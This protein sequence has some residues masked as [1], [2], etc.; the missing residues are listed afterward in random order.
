MTSTATTTPPTTTVWAKHAL[1]H[2][3]AD[4]RRVAA[5]SSTNTTAIFLHTGDG[6]SPELHDPAQG[7]PTTFLGTVNDGPFVWHIFTAEST[8]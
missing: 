3:L 1:G 7:E 8:R 4:G 2:T 5:V 6:G